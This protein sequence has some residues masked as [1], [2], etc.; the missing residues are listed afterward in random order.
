VWLRI[1]LTLIL[2]GLTV[3]FYAVKANRVYKRTYSMNELAKIEQKLWPQISPVLD[4]DLL[5]TDIDKGPWAMAMTPMQFCKKHR[6]L[7]EVKPTKQDIF[8]RQNRVEVVLNRGE[9]NRI[10]ALQVGAL[11]QGVAKLPPHARA[12]FAA[13]AARLNA[14]T[15]PALA[16]LKRLTETAGTKLDISGTEELLKK[17]VNTPLVQQIVQRH[18]YVLTVMA[19]MLVGAREDGVQASAD[20]LWL[21]VV[22]RRLWYMLNTIGRQTP[23][24]EVGGP[25]AHWLAEKELGVPL[26]VP[27]VE[28]VVNAVELA[29]KEVV[30]KPDEVSQK[31]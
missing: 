12:L 10:F 27:M 15:E 8:A 22:D 31:E 26:F 24:I 21:K 7:L 17:H 20:F 29:L 19:S 3:L 13:F 6:L 30:Y 16:L 4:L 2:L 25:F 23:F 11:W 28:E 14:D 18:A 1:P 9:A 5:K